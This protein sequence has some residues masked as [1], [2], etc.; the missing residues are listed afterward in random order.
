M[1]LAQVKGRDKS[2]LGGVGRDWEGRSGEGRFRLASE[3]STGGR[4]EQAE[5]GWEQ[6]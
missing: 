6:W 3:F 2:L 1:T 4:G 5:G